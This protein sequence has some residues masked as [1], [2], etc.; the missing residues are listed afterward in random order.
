MK[1]IL[2]TFLLISSILFVASCED[3]N[4]VYG[5]TD[6]SACNYNIL[7]EHN[8][9]SCEYPE[10]GYDCSG[11]WDLQVGD[12]Y[13]GGMV[14][15]IDESQM[16]GFISAPSTI[17]EFEWGC[18]DVNV[19]GAEGIA[20]GSGYQNSIEILNNDCELYSP[21]EGEITASQAA[22]AYEN[23]GYS[24]WYL[25]SKDELYEMY[26]TIGNGGPDGNIG[27]FSNGWYWSSSEHNQDVNDL[28]WGMSF[29]NNNMDHYAKYSKGKVRPIR[30]F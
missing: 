15:Y 14:F 10:P 5:C 19:I 26:I 22:D 27:G 6:S 9:D 23:E 30:S 2:Y 20:I 11:N 18:Y 3:D 12:L 13:Q 21:E 24:D 7:S 4:T 28:A 1:K 17:G 25:P 16:H 8:N 29:Y